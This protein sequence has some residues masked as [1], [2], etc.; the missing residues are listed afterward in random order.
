MSSIKAQREGEENI[1]YSLENGGG[2]KEDMTVDLS[3]YSAVSRIM[4]KPHSRPRRVSSKFGHLFYHRRDSLAVLGVPV[5]VNNL[6]VFEFV[7]SATAL[8]FLLTAVPSL[9]DEGA[10]TVVGARGRFRFGSL[11]AGRAGD[12]GCNLSNRVDAIREYGM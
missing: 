9:A 1:N 7:L 11:H 3:S 2:P 8:S 5:E 10:S 12:W 6:P 4:W